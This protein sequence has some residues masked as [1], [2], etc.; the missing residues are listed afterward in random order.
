MTKKVDDLLEDLEA[1]AKEATLP[2]N[3]QDLEKEVIRL[4]KIIESYNLSDEMHVTNIEYIC[5]KTIDDMKKLALTGSL[6]SDDAKTLDILHKNLRM[7]RSNFAKKEAP[8]KTTT[9][10]ELLKIVNGTKK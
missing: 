4:R 3:T 2:S 8:G 6:T 1:K 5:Q 7:A 9:E 10:A